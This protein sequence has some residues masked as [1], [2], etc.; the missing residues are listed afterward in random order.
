[1]NGEGY[2]A[3]CESM[4]RCQRESDQQ[5]QSLLRQTR[6]LK[7]ENEELCTQMS[8]TGPSQSWQQQTQR[9]TSRHIDETSFPKNA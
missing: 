6:R 7:E 3:W 5:M 9:T 1:M 8:S 4:E 2:F